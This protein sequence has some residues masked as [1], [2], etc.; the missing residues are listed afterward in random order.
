MV[1]VVAVLVA[2]PLLKVVQLGLQPIADAESLEIGRYFRT[3]LFMVV[4]VSALCLILGVICAWLV[5]S[6]KF[7]AATTFEWMLFLPLAMPGY[8]VAFIYTDLASHFVPWL[9]TEMR[10]PGGAALILGFTLY[11]YVYIAM[12]AALVEVSVCA[13][14]AGRTMGLGAWR[15]LLLLVLPLSRPSLV[16]ALIL[17]AMEVMNDYGT[18]NHLAVATFT[19][20]IFDVWFYGNDINGAARL[21]LILLLCVLLLLIP[22]RLAN[23]RRRYYQATGRYRPMTKEKLDG[24]RGLAAFCACGVPCFFGFVLP[25]IALTVMSL[26]FGQGDWSV[27]VAS[28]INSLALALPTTAAAIVLGGFL[29]FMAMYA[30]NGWQKF[31]LSLP[32]IGYAVPGAV[33]ALGVLAVLLGIDRGLNSVAELWGGGGFGLLLAASAVAILYG[34]A[35]RFLTLPFTIL[36]SGLS[37]I[38]PGLEEAAHTLGKGS[39]WCMMRLYLP[40]LKGSLLAAGMLIF[41]DCMKELPMT[42]ILRPPDFDTLATQVWQYAEDEQFAAAAPAALI[43]VILGIL[44]VIVANYA[45]GRAR[46]GSAAD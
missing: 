17:V 28:G 32:A 38:R 24:W 41:V 31:A 13:L 44:A 25:F 30:K 23:R 37:R 1:A 8:I 35:V 11:P 20:G 6:Y 45:L 34:Y 43:I 4:A 33:L 14:E 42:L 29:A 10:S 12:R 21:A 27:F 9:D 2:L 22:E 46:P 39:S 7:F 3:T 15:R 5:S 19:Y 16:I 26:N 40:L 18:V 36:G